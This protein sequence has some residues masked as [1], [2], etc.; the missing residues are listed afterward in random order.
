MS[1]VRFHLFAAT[2]ALTFAVPAVAQLR[3]PVVR[4]PIAVT[5]AAPITPMVMTNSRLATRTALAAIAN[6][7]K[8]NPAQTSPGQ[9]PTGFSLDFDM[10]GGPAFM[11][12]EVPGATAY[13]VE[14]A[15]DG[16]QLWSLAGSTCGSPNTIKRVQVGMGRWQIEFWEASGGITPRTTYVYR[17]KALGDN[18]EM[19]WN[20]T[21]WT[22][23]DAPQAIWET[24]VI[25][26]STATL[27]FSFATNPVTPPNEWVLA[28]PDGRQWNGIVGFSGPN[29][30]QVLG[31]QPGNYTFTLTAKW[32][33]TWDP[34][35]PRVTA[36]STSQTTITI[37]I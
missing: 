8:C 35:M 22:A 2:S 18:G 20:S 32:V 1:S 10:P 29:T 16:N 24:P 23:P 12:P 3:T 25:T 28:A 11:W 4:T 9:A 6:S 7:M 5:L 17:V 34:A 27:K 30:V 19:G 15:V 31:L 37:K 13:V 14:R 36:T 21:R 26:G 33:Q